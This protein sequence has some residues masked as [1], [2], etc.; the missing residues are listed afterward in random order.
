VAST[1]HWL[2][3][4]NRDD[5]KRR[6]AFAAHVVD[7]SM[8]GF[9]PAALGA[10][11][12]RTRLPRLAVASWLAAA[13][14]V[15]SSSV[16]RRFDGS[17]SLRARD[18]QFNTAFGG[19]VAAT[20]ACCLWSHGAAV[21]AAPLGLVLFGSACKLASAY[22]VRDAMAPRSAD[23]PTARRALDVGTGVFHA[24]FGVAIGRILPM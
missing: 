3:F 7:L 19:I 5:P 8:M 16:R 18:A 22:R 15:H 21:C 12:L 13:V 20:A 11:A 1:I 10:Q 9:L 2:T 17:G 6:V 4:D 24:A 14:G 23:D